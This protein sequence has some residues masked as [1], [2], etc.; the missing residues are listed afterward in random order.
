MSSQRQSSIGS[1]FLLRGTYRGLDGSGGFG[2]LP[3]RF[4]RDL[5]CPALFQRAQ[6]R[7]ER[8]C[9]GDGVAAQADGF[10]VADARL[11]GALIAVHGGMMRGDHAGSEHP[12]DDV[13]WLQGLDGSARRVA[14]IIR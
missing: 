6:R 10:G 8:A 4:L 7:I 14:A 11:H 13:A 5:A 9:G 3:V 1:P 12:F 2:D